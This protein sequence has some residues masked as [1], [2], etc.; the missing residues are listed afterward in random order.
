MHL[1]ILSI[2]IISDRLK[3]EGAASQADSE[4]VAGAPLATAKALHAIGS[5]MKLAESLM[6]KAAAIK[7]IE[8]KWVDDL[9]S[10]INLLCDNRETAGQE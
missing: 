9:A 2:G 4:Y 10:H 8:I 5:V 7:D 6:L 3:R 1:E